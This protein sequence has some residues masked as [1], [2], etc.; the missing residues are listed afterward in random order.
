MGRDISSIESR[1]LITLKQ[2][3]PLIFVT[4]ETEIIIVECHYSYAF[5]LLKQKR[6][7]GLENF[8]LLAWTSIT[9]RA[10]DFVIICQAGVVTLN[11]GSMTRDVND[12]TVEHSGYCSSA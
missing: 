2:S 12:H 4:K 9:L 8:F 11:C 1:G 6:K 10:G 7:K 3:Q 5:E